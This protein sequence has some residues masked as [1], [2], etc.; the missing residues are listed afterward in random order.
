MTRSTFA[1]ILIAPLLTF[2]GPADSEPLEPPAGMVWYAPG[3]VGHAVLVPY[4]FAVDS[5]A[6]TACESLSSGSWDAVGDNGK[7]FGVFQIH[8]PA[9]G[10]RMVGLGLSP[11]SESDRIAYAARLWAEQGESFRAWSCAGK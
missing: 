6:I 9:H 10:A 2:A 11:D 3:P 5:V 4:Q 8:M 7:S 1:A